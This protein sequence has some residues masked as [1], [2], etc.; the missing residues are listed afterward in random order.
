[1]DGLNDHEL[2]AVL[3]DVPSTQRMIV[4]S[5]PN[6]TTFRGLGG[7]VTLSG[8]HLFHVFAFSAERDGNTLTWGDAGYLTCSMENG[9]T[10]TIGSNTMNISGIWSLD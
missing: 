4:F 7:G 6:W 10:P 3:W 9:S 8:S 2:F 5:R 1:M